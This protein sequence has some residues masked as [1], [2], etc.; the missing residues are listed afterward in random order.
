MK[1]QTDE[2]K[3]DTMKSI[4]L[5]SLRQL[6]LKMSSSPGRIFHIFRS[7]KLWMEFMLF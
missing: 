4:I 5:Y 7:T 1:I 3:L 6:V 2:T